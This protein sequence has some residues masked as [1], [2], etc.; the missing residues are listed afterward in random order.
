MKKSELVKIIKEEIKKLKEAGGQAY[1]NMELVN[2]SLEDA[3]KFMDGKIDL[4]KELPQ[5]DSNF[6]Y[7][8]K[9]AGMG[10]TKRKEMPVIDDSDVK[11]FQTRLKNGNLDIAKPFA[12]TTDTSNPFPEGLKGFDAKDFLGRE[13]KDGSK[14]DDIIPI[15]IKQVSVGKL[16]PIQKQIYFDKSMN[17]TGKFGVK[18]TTDF[19]TKKTFFITS[20]DNYIIDGHHRFLSGVILDPT[21]K[22][23]TLSIDMPI[24]KLLPL[25]RAY[26]DSLGN[27]RNS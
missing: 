3:R 18:G 15:S 14:N 4:D 26:G 13:L 21:M 8:S 12:K 1:G 2:T 9:L 22:V 20:A 25:A 7:A 11:K 19:L 27:K 10:K 17:S 6:K 16:K 5:F 24:K 23:N